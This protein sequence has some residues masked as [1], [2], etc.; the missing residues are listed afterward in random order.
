MPSS[1]NPFKNVDFSDLPHTSH[2]T[3]P[4]GAKLAFRAYP[5]AGAAAKGGVVLVHGSSADSS[6]MHMMAKRFAAAGY[7]ACA[8]G[9]RGHGESGAK[10]HIDYVGDF[11][12]AVLPAIDHISLTLDAAAIDAAVESM[13]HE[14][15]DQAIQRTA[16]R[17]AFQLAM[18][19]HSVGRDGRSRQRSLI[20]GFTRH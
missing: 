8:L 9:I 7:A 14:T 12:G 16:G 6:S 4:D 18:T 20:F 10:G 13:S 19:A 17:R 15:A 1:N 5:A 11:P 2:F 3:A